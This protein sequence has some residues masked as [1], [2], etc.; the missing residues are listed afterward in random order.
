MM[1]K[2]IERKEYLQRLIDWKDEKVIKVITGIR[3]CGKSTLLT[4]FKEYLMQND[5]TSEQIITINFEELEYEHLLNYKEL[6]SYIKEKLQPNKT[7]YILLD[8]IQKVA[9]FEKVIDS[10]YVK[11]NIDI[12]IT[13][14]NAYLLSSDLA[15]F[16]TGRYIEISMLPL[17]FKEYCE[18]TNSQGDSALQEYM[19]NGGF[20]YVASIA[21]SQE[22]VETYLEGIYNTV[23]IKDIE[24]RQQRN[25]YDSTD[26]KTNDVLLLKT[27]SKYL[28]SC[29]GSPIS[30]RNITNYLVSNGRHVSNSTVGSYLN[31]LYEAFIFYPVE[32]FDING[33]ELLKA[34]KKWYIVD[35]GIRNYILPKKHYDLGFSIENIVYFELLRRNFNVNIGKLGNSEVDFVAKKNNEI[36]YIQVS[37]D[38]TSEETFNR[39]IK[40]LRSIKDNYTKIILTLDKYTSGNY[41]GIHVINLID[42][43]LN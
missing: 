4:M 20:P 15:T 34:N 24:E 33:K 31:A 19:N 43:L 3:R 26:R 25:N 2:R 12:Y 23:I 21:K 32:R 42:W 16:L 37:A 40:P 35:L 36:T 39:E 17:S 14:S 28:A 41:D 10:L 29:I 9:N 7:T 22:M 18:I 5:V 13:G 8:E 6:Y 38:L 11:D 27:I 1:Y 30:A